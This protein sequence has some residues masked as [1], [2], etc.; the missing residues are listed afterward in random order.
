MEDSGDVAPARIL[1]EGINRQT[2]V[3]R[4]SLNARHILI[5]RLIPDTLS[6]G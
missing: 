5:V 1:R 2:V 6:P 3:D 4:Q